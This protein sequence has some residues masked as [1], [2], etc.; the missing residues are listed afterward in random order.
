MLRHSLIE[1]DGEPI[2]SGLP[3]L[4]WHRL[5]LADVAQCQKIRLDQRICCRRRRTPM[6]PIVDVLHWRPET[7]RATTA[8]RFSNGAVEIGVG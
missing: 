7:A 5:F 8:P 4:D 1:H 2:Q 3:V 6:L